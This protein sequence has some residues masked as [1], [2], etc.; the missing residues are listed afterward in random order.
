M[1][2]IV[3]DKAENIFSLR[4]VLELNGFEV[5][6]ADSGEEAL[7]KILDRSYSLIILD[8]Q[9]PGMDGFEVAET[10]TGYSKTRDVPIIFLSAVNTDKKFITKGYT[11][12]GVDYVTKPIDTDIFILKVKTLHKLYEQNRQ[13]SEMHLNLLEEVEVRKQVERELKKT[14]LEQRSILESMQQIAFTMKADGDIEFVNQHWYLYSGSEKELPAIHPDDKHLVGIQQVIKK[15]DLF[16]AEI[17]IKNL[18]TGEFRYHLLKLV[19]VKQGEVIH[20]WVGTLTDIQEQ[21]AANEL[22]EM[23]VK[24]RTEELINKNDLLEAS[25]HELQQFASVVSHDLKEPLRKIQVFSSIIK[26]RF[27]RQDEGAEENMDRVL[28]ASR[29]MKDLINDLLNYSRLS[30][31]SLF[32]KTDLAVLLNDIIHDLEFPINEKQATITLGHLPSI[33]AIPGQLRQVFQNLISNALKFSKPGVTP[34]IVINAEIFASP[35]KTDYCRITV[36]D[37]GIGFDDRYVD[38]IF[39]LFQR[40]HDRQTY[41]GTGIGLAIVK[42]IVEKHHG[43]VTATGIEGVG[44]TFILCLPLEQTTAMTQTDIITG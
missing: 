17:R 6:S 4:R 16:I 25:N 26:E 30:V 27:L 23:K 10:M 39:T 21:K 40:L 7:K 9:M 41:D 35:D 15:G 29:R 19:P 24:E 14:M 3:D 13:L 22:L 18:Q 44:A 37:N 33:L 5:D 36:T 1:I 8:V 34:A 28:D 12:G 2:L 20:K 38:K 11:S 42:K 31:G 32:Q 43:T